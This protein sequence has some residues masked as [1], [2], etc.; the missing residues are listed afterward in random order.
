MIAKRPF[1]SWALLSLACLCWMAGCAPTHIALQIESS[2][3]PDFS[4]DTYRIFSFLP[5]EGEKLLTEK[6]LVLIRGELE[7]KGF[8]HDDGNP[9]ILIA[10]KAGTTV[11]KRQEPVVSRPVP[12]LQPS[13]E[14]GTPEIHYRIEGGGYYTVHIRQ[15]RMVVREAAG[16]KPDDPLWQGEVTSEGNEDISEVAGCLVSGLLRD[17]PAGRGKSHMTL[18]LSECR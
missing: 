7:K 18:K 9:R 1:L 5:P 8:V 4:A 6:L 10:M 12:V 16:K 13:R 3:Q 11:Q 14:G 17:Y 15:I 2:A